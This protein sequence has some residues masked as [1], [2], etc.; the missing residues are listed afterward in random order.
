MPVYINPDFRRLAGGLARLFEQAAEDSFFA[1]PEWYDLI[2]RYGLPASAE[3]RVYTDERPGSATALLLRTDTPECR[4]RLTSLANAYSVEHGVICL[5][6]TDLEAGFAAIISEILAERPRWE[7]LSLIELDPRHASYE[8]A[9]CSLRRAGFLVECVFN[10]GTWYEETVALDFA[11]YLAARP[12]ELRNTW[13]RK[14]IRLERSRRLSAAFFSDPEGIDQ[15]IADYLTIYAA[16]WKPPEFRLEF[17]PALLRLAAELGALRLGIYYIDAAPAA[18]QFWILWRGRAVIYKLAHARQ[19]DD[20]SL[21][22]LL[23]MEMAQRVLTEDRPREITLG[24]GDDPFKKLWLPRRRERW[25]ISAANP[26]TWRGLG[27]GLKREAAKACHRLR[28][29]PIAPSA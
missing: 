18:A 10:S 7:R 28:G 2:A 6:E 24:R 26:R 11:E 17:I 9:T 3:I 1:L 22:T 16:S 23:T 5:P 29:E 20:L 13:R 25:G 8:A 14:R 12:S 15:A 4:R 19:F 27:F 21:G